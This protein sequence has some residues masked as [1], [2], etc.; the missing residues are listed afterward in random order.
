[1]AGENDYR[2]RCLAVRP[3]HC[4]ICTSTRRIEVHHID[5]DRSNN[6]LTNLKVVCGDCH[7]KIHNARAGY[8]D[9]F[10]KLETSDYTPLE[11]KVAGANGDGKWKVDD[12]DDED[13]TI[14]LECE[15]ENAKDDESYSVNVE[16]ESPDNDDEDDS[17][18]V[19]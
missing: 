4:S 9:W 6:I 8:K 19:S 1:M 10:N 7:D 13:G 18:W 5:G 11:S 16:D 14:W 12:E 17:C 3:N 15:R 2:E